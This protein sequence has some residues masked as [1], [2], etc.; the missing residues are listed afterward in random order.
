MTEAAE[1]E[2]AGGQ[3]VGAGVHN[4]FGTALTGRGAKPSLGGEDRICGSE[5]GEDSWANDLL[6]SYLGLIAVQAP[7]PTARLGNPTLSEHHSGDSTL[8]Y[9]PDSRLWGF[10]SYN[11]ILDMSLSFLQLFARPSR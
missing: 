7:S 3:N 5:S 2:W 1:A 6:S 8:L 10:A 9:N 4:L 11:L